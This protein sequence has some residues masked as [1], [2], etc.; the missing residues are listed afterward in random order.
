MIEKKPRHYIIIILSLVLNY[1]SCCFQSFYTMPSTSI[2]IKNILLPWQLFH[3]PILEQ[4]P[5]KLNIHL[6]HL[7]HLPA[8]ENMCDH[9]HHSRKTLAV[10]VAWLSKNHYRLFSRKQK[11][12]KH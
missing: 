7:H 6:R 9:S 5:I 11:I 10:C 4:C 2:E 3:K 12:S 8:A 1:P